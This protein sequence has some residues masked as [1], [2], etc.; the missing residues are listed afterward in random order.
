MSNF[1]VVYT[2]NFLPSLKES[3]KELKESMSLSSFKMVLDILQ[4][5]QNWQNF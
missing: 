1:F 3:L 4:Y 5:F 2:N